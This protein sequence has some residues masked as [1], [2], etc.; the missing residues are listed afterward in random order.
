[1]HTQLLFILTLATALTGC[2]SGGSAVDCKQ[3]TVPKFA[4]ITGWGKCT[5]CHSSALS[6]ASRA[7]APASINFDNYDDAVSDADLALSELDEGAMPPAGSPK[8]SAAEKD[9]IVNWASCDTPQ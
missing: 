4:E 1:M 2:T 3:V 6:G 8:L 7:G 5:S 9:Q